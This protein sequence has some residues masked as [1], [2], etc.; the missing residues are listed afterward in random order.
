MILIT[1]E[2]GVGGELWEGDEWRLAVGE[3]MINGMVASING[4][5]I[6]AGLAE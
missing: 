3:R 5:L 4:L 1:G 2:R 6:G